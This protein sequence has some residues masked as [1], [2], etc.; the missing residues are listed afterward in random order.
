[1]NQSD[2]ITLK[3]WIGNEADRL[4]IT[5]GAVRARFQRGKYPGVHVRRIN[6]RV[7]M[8]SVRLFGDEK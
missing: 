4:G 3:E 2:E 8:V 1:M 5:I 7:V 6:K